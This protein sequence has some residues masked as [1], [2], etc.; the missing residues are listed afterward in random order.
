MNKPTAP[1]QKQPRRGGCCLGALIGGLFRTA[2]WAAGGWI[3]YSHL[4]LDH[5]V[6]LPKALPADQTWIPCPPAGAL[7]AYMDRL[8]SERPL[9]LIHSVNAAASAYE[10]RPLFQHYRG[11]RPVLA[12][13][14]PGF[15]FSTRSDIDY[16]PALYVQAVLAG[17]QELG[18]APADII[19]LS[20][21]SEFTAQVAL[22]RP[23]LV[24]SLTLISPTGLSRRPDA[25]PP[26]ADRARNAQ[27]L[28][29]VR[30]WA[31]PLYDLLTTRLVLRSYLQKSF[32]GAPPDALLDYAYATA[33]QPGAEHA[34][35]A[36]IS[37][38]LFTPDAARSLYAQVA[39]PTLV[40]YDRDAY[41][42]FELLPELL[43][44]NPAWRAERITPTLGLPHFEQL[45]ATTQAID[46]FWTGLA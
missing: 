31:R 45:D 8:G 5:Q 7:N 37:G 41:V 14:L 24:H 30:L 36:F 27:R 16:S 13:D 20:L 32:T 4:K 3:A 44:Q 1:Q 29:S 17:L 25:P 2:F 15:G 28:L 43:R 12:L 46:R 22:Q 11:S 33:H 9:L 19:A 39:T 38:K 35:L 10:M 40:I 23:D 21:G 26:N 6:P 42:N 18:G 34:P